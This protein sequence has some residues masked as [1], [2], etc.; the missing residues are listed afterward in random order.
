[1]ALH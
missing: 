1:M